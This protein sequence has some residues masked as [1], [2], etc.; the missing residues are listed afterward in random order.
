MEIERRSDSLLHILYTTIQH[1][2]SH[3]LIRKVATKYLESS[4]E[5][6]FDLTEKLYQNIGS[7]EDTSI[8]L[9]L[10]NLILD[11]SRS[12]GMMPYIAKGMYQRY[13]IERNDFS[14]LKESYYIG[15]YVLHYADFLPQQDRIELYYKLGVHA[16][17]LRIYN[18]SIEHC[19]KILTE[20]D[21]SNPYDNLFL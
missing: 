8:K 2:S 1:K 7:I 3:E 13:L 14:K 9:S 12:H 15:K 5:D 4:N 16:Y 19:K 6:S 10:Y 18:E 21:G 11:H 17:N 20:D